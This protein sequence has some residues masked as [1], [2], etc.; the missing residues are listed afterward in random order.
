MDGLVIYK[1]HWNTSRCLGFFR[2]RVIGSLATSADCHSPPLTSRR[3][4]GEARALD[5]SRSQILMFL[6][7]PNPMVLASS[8][9]APQLEPPAPFVQLYALVTPPDIECRACMSSWASATEGRR[10]NSGGSCIL[11]LNIRVVLCLRSHARTRQADI[12]TRL[13]SSSDL[14]TS[15]CAGLV[16]LR[17]CYLLS[18]QVTPKLDDA[19]RSSMNSDKTLIFDIK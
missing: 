17:H 11:M 9:I 3:F 19:G 6:K 16:R 12:Q 2:W 18:F 13:G 10:I 8:R 7:I 14:S 1:A 5:G 4:F 15:S